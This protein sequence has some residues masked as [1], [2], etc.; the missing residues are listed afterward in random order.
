MSVRMTP[1]QSRG[2]AFLLLIL[3]LV[4]VSAAIA[5]PTLKLHYRYD[6]AIAQ[7]QDLLG[8]YQRMIA[9]KPQVETALEEVRQRDGRRFFFKN[10]AANLAGAELQELVRAGIERSGGRV[11]TS[12]N[13][14]PK[15]DGDFYKI[16]VN[17]QFFA[18]TENLQKAIQALESQKPYLIIDGMTLRPMNTNRNFKPAPGQEPEI[19]AQIEVSGWAYRSSDS[20]GAP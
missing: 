18:T 2:L 1:L 19:N 17:V 15:E 12:Q 13:I 4:G 5:V 11:T 14:A 10:T 6:K 8:R 20:G 3:A 7:Q 16:S 9:Q